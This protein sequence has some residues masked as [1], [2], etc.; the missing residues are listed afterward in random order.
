MIVA[1]LETQYAFDRYADGNLKEGLVY[2][3]DFNGNFLDGY[4]IQDGL[5]TKRYVADSGV[6]HAGFFLLALIQNFDDPNCWNT[7]NLPGDN[8][9]AEVVVTAPARNN[10]NSF[11]EIFFYNYD[12]P[13]SGND[14]PG[15]GTG[16]GGS[17]SSSFVFNEDSMIFEEGNKPLEEYDDKCT[18][19]NR[20]WEL[21][22]NSGDEFA[23]V[24]TTD[25]AILITEQLNS[26]GGGIGGIYQYSGITYYQYPISQG[27]PARGYLGQIESAGR[28]FIP[29][30]AT[31]HSHTPCINDGTDGITNNEIDLDQNFA[32][33]YPNINHFIIGCNAIGQ[34]NGDSNQ[35]FNI[36]SG[37]LST[38]CNNIN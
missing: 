27:A 18:G 37:S 5:T 20:I 12:V 25:G 17:S 32:S 31:I 19:V 14:I 4:K 7:D 21:S 35:V 9:L 6:Q 3:N 30:T 15:G 22:Q 34:F 11:Q 33:S 2:Y 10:N 38:L 24:L 29:I 36:Q 26:N 1:A 23:A 8:Q 13:T 28:Y 16:G